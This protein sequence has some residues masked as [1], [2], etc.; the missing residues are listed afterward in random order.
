MQ[1]AARKWKFWAGLW[2]LALAFL[3]NRLSD[4]GRREAEQAPPFYFLPKAELLSPLL[5]G[6]E[7]VTADLLY[8]RGLGYFAEELARRGP[9]RFLEPLCTLIV[10]LDPRFE[11]AYIW[12]GTLL[13]YGPRELTRSHVEASNRVLKRGIAALQS[14]AYWPAGRS[15]WR[16]PFMLG[17]NYYH[18]LRDR[19]SGAYYF[20]MAGGFPNAPPLLKTLPATLLMREGLNDEAVDL[21]ETN[22]LIE[23][24]R[25]RLLLA[26]DER[27]KAELLARIRY[28]Q[29]KLGASRVNLEDLL[30]QSEEWER[31]A[32][33]Y[34]QNFAYLPFEQYLLIRGDDAG[35]AD[36]PGHLG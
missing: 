27:Q 32:A 4:F 22:L 31:I 30:R 1:K 17:F 15:T 12:G 25:S 5:F 29:R 13:I 34:G 11:K 28:Y 35:D 7:T 3:F 20:N 8:L 19:R 24:L 21:I 2:L 36:L 6:F 10:E 26:G 23:T 18:E 14:A 9:M 33:S 16:I